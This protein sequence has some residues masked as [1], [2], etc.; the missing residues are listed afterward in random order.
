MKTAEFTINQKE[1]IEFKKRRYVRAIVSNALEKGFLK[2][3]GAC[4][5]CASD[6]RPNAHHVDYGNPLRVIWL[7]RDCHG[8][9]HRKEHA[10]NP[11]NNPQTPLPSCVQKYDKVPVT[12]MLP[13]RNFLNLH[14]QSKKI[15]KSIAEMV[16]EEILKKFPV[17]NQQLEF[18][19]EDN[20]D[21]ISQSIND[22]RIQVLAENQRILQ[23]PKREQ[24]SKLWS[25]RNK[26]V[27]RMAR[28]LS[29]ILS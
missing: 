10:L 9:V 19:F 25:E 8:L 11:K 28:E 22:K 3:P 6:C 18:N 14:A 26:N 13:V 1:L 24:L 23:Q 17:Q 5:L 2:R 12:F 27:Q 4:D 7:C 21:G 20:K 15:G 16:R 29:T